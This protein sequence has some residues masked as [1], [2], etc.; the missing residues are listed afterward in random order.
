[1]T[2]LLEHQLHALGADIQRIGPL[3]LH[4]CLLLDDF[5]QPDR[6]HVILDPAARDGQVFILARTFHWCG[7]LDGA[8]LH[9][10][11]EA[12]SRW[13]G[14][15]IPR[16][17]RVLFDRVELG[18]TAALC[19]D[20]FYRGAGRFAFGTSSRTLCRAEA[21]RLFREQMEADGVARWKRDAAYRAVRWFGA[22][23]WR[24]A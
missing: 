19:H 15:S 17:V 7:E 8:E 16:L 5:A 6:P 13:D 2:R 22:G 14:A 3:S 12:G 21:D 1:M 4:A 18:A 20:G 23:R 9:I 24:A 11:A 10:T